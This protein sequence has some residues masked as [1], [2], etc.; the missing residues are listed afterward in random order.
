MAPPTTGIRVFVVDD[1]PIIASTVASILRLHGFSAMSFTNPVQALLAAAA[2]LPQLLI[3]DVVM[4]EMSGVD[5]AIQI[6][7][8][9]P[10]CKVLL[11]SGQANTAEAL[12]RDHGMGYE[13]EVL[14]KPVHPNE[15]LS[16]IRSVIETRGSTGEIL[17]WPT[18]AE[19]Q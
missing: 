3:S 18:T 19:A 6:Q 14:L 11:F 9:C 8:E 17:A 15:L 10:A 13:F 1:E 2:G 16:R 7:R 4:F 5:L 12:F